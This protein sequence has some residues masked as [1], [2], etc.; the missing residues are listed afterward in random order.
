MSYQSGS[1]VA[2]EQPTTA[3]WNILWNNDASFNDGTG[4]GDD[5]ILTR[6][7]PA[8]ELFEQTNYQTDNDNTIA[9]STNQEVKYQGGWGQVE[10]NGSTSINVTITF[11]QAFTTL[12]G[13]VATHG[14]GRSGTAANLS[15]FT[16]AAAAGSI[17]FPGVLTVSNA[18]IT[19]SRTGTYGA[20]SYYAYSWLA[21]GLM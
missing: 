19:L 6:H 18:P 20:G 1:F 21:W 15:N 16:T 14:P 10:G 13:F 11:P 2:D 4:I 17:I 7:V 12:L 3:K 9:S 5:T 8:G